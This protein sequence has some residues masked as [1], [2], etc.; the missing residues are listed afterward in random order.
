MVSVGIFADVPLD[1]WGARWI[2]AAFNAGLIPAC[3]TDPELKFC[4]D[5]PLT[6]AVAAFMMTQAES[7]DVP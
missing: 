4:P 5:E 7:Q 2:E 6:R 3:E 1:G